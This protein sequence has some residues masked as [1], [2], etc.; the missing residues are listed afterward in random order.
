[1]SGTRW[2]PVD[3]GGSAVRASCWAHQRFMCDATSISVFSDAATT[4]LVIGAVLATRTAPSAANVSTSPRAAYR[5]LVDQAVDRLARVA[6]KAVSI[7][8]RDGAG[9][10]ANLAGRHP[11]GPSHHRRWST[12]NRR[13]RLDRRR[14]VAARAIGLWYQLS[15]IGSVAFGMPDANA[16]ADISGEERDTGS[17]AHAAARS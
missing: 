8:T 16:L 10:D 5:A 12:H 11:V 3:R 6:R 17:R 7:D 15:G 4:R 14:G 1:M 2:S 13:S 9:N